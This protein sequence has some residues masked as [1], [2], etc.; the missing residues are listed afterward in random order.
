MRSFVVVEV[1]GARDRLPDLL[2]VSEAHAFKKF[3]LHRV[4]A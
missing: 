3:V 1:Y 2:N 4:V